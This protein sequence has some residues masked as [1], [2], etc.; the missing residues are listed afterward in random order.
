MPL[1]TRLPSMFS[2]TMELREASE[3]RDGEEQRVG[4]RGQAAREH[5]MNGVTQARTSAS[6]QSMA[7]IT[8]RAPTNMTT[9]SAI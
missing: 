5:K 4:V 1:T 2:L 7:N 9:Q 8:H 6:R 3:L